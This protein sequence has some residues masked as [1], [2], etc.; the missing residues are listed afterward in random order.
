M[1]NDITIVF[2]V[3]NMTS[4]LQPMDHGVISTFKPYHLVNTFC[5]ATAAIDMDDGSWQ[6]QL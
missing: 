5:K 1:Y 3:A 2:M 6:I 4:I